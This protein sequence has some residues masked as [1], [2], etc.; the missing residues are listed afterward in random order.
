MWNTQIK[1]QIIYGDDFVKIGNYEFNYIE[2]IEINE[3]I[4]IDNPEH[5]AERYKKKN[6]KNLPLLEEGLLDFC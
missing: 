6:K 3:K 2:T 5:P 4:K 1:E